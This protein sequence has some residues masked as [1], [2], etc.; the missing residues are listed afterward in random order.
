MVFEHLRAPAKVFNPGLGLNNSVFDSY[1]PLS[2]VMMVCHN[3]YIVALEKA[4][5]WTDVDYSRG[6]AFPLEM[7]RRAPLHLRIQISADSKGFLLGEVRLSAFRLRQLDLWACDKD[8]MA[9]ATRLLGFNMPLLRCLRMSFEKYHGGDVISRTSSGNHP[10]LR[11]L[12]LNHFLWIPPES[13]GITLPTALTHLRISYFPDVSVAML[14]RLLDATPAL[15]VLELCQC[16]VLDLSEV[17]THTTTLEHL[18]HLTLFCMRTAVAAIFMPALF[19]PRATSVGLSF[20]VNTDI[21]DS[22]L[23][24]PPSWHRATRVH[25]DDSEEYESLSIELED[26]THRVALLLNYEAYED[27]SAWPLPVPTASQLARVTSAHVC[28]DDSGWQLLRPFMARVP[29]L[30]T[31]DVETRAED[32]AGAGRMAE[33]LRD[34]LLQEDPVLCPGLAEVALLSTCNVHGLT[35]HLAPALRKRKRDARQV[36]RLR[37]WIYVDEYSTSEPVTIG[38]DVGDALAEHV[39]TGKV[40]HEEGALWKRDEERWRRENEFWLVSEKWC[41]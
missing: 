19:L 25:V 34:A 31:L 36:E 7:S 13:P 2:S 16:D 5:L 9:Y 41:D 40:E 10:S 17:P 23:P 33:A 28:L 8:S 14:T 35:E 32:A 27:R 11:G 24:Q 29:S 1:K 20:E 22:V 38:G 12:V 18:T 6:L 26:D 21:D 39:G 15:E 37:T 30:A 4:S 3:W